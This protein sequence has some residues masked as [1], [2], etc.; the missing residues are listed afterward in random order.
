ML[1]GWAGTLV[2]DGYGG[3]RALFDQGYVQ[4]AGCW[5]HVRRKFFDQYK[6][7]GSQVALRQ[8]ESAGV[9]SVA[10]AQATGY[11]PGLGDTAG[12]R[13]HAEALA[14]PVD[15]S[16]GWACAD[17]QQPDGECDTAGMCR[18]A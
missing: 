11:G 9:P 16:G 12:H 8:T 15:L 2:V 4:E 10:V 6:A 13:L 5:A 3:Y 1:S 14:E 7:N 17:R 18:S